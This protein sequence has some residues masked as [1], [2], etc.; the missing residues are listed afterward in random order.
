MTRMTKLTHERLLSVMDFDPT[1]GVFRWR[2]RASN[3][4]KIGDRAGVVS[5][6]GHRFI[7][8]DGEKFQATRLTIF[9]V[10][11][12]WPMNDVK[13]LN[14]NPDDCSIVNL[15]EMSRI[16]AAR[17]RGTLSTNTSGVRGVSPAKRGHWKAA[18]TAN[19]KQV[20]LGVYPTKE[21]ASEIYEFAMDALKDAKT[22]EECKSALNLIIQHRRKKVA[23]NRLVRSGRPKAW[24][25]FETFAADVGYADEE[26]T[27]IAAADEGKAVGPDNFRWLLKPQGEFDRTTKVGNAAYMKAYRD[28]NPDRWRHTHLLKN[29]GINEVEYQAMVEKQGGAFCIICE[30]VLENERLA[31]DHDHITGEPRGLLCKQCNYAMGQFH[32][33][34]VLLR[35]AAKYLDGGTSLKPSAFDLSITAA[36]AASPHRDW[37]NVAT[38]GFGA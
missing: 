37:L 4:I 27:T 29:Y 26:H 17:L 2:I 5:D 33:D 12:E 20:N 34:S 32:D 14:G 30:K 22:A 36:S 10:R 7:T 21:E 1:T 13:A 28:A 11:G 6:K 15:Q 31:V 3:R 8:V 35:R 16:E 38:L 24:T 9:Y 18:I 23:W 25:E 19:Y